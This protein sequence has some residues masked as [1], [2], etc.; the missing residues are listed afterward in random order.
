MTT[1]GSPRSELI[2]DRLAVSRQA[3]PKQS[4]QDRVRNFEETYTGFELPMAIVEAGRCLDCPSA[5]CMQAC[6][7]GNDIPAALMLLERG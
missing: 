7:V 6:P 4:P 3:V 1:S 5:P 2:Q